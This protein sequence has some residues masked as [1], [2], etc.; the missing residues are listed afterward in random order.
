[1]V[2]T[3]IGQDDRLEFTGID[4]G[5]FGHTRKSAVGS[6]LPR[7]LLCCNFVESTRRALVGIV[8]I[9]GSRGRKERGN[10]VAGSRVR[11][12]VYLARNFQLP[13]TTGSPLTFAI[14]RRTN[15]CCKHD[16]VRACA[17]TLINIS[18][19]V[20]RTRVERR[21]RRR[22]IPTVYIRSPVHALQ[23]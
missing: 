4:G 11:G 13:P 3:E 15:G 6:Q 18:N 5:P 12:L 21:T 16:T 9:V 17:L 1:M 19:S 23:N 2:D 8:G 20:E 14:D 10:C 7:D 22:A